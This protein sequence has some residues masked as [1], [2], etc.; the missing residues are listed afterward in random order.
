MCTYTLI[1][2]IQSLFLS[3]LSTEAVEYADCTS[4]GGKNSLMKLP[5]DCEWQRI[6]LEDGIL[7]AG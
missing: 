1:E 2:R 4:A 3:T 6:M 5:V 7:G